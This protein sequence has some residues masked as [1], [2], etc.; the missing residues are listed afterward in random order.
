VIYLD[1]SALAKLIVVEDESAALAGWL[2]ERPEELL[3]T[4]VLGRV[5]LVRAARRRGPEAVARALGLLAELALVPVSAEVLDGAWILDP[6]SV[7]S[8]DALHL[9]SAS[10]LGQEL[11]ALVAYDERLLAGARSL[12]LVAVAPGS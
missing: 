6:P 2:D 5:E 3:A 9:A 4:S 11:T 1:T 8:L 7:R 10:S 12:G